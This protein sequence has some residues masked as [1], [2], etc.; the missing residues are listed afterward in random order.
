MYS[1]FLLNPLSHDTV[2]TI[3]HTEVVE[4]IQLIEELEATLK[5]YSQ[6]K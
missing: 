3:V 6:K 5:P 2:M 1:K 4:S